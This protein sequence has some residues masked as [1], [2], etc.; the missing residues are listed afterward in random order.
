MAQHGHPGR[1]VLI[2][3]V[4]EA[5]VQ[6]IQIVYLL[7]RR[8]S[9][10]QDGVLHLFAIA[11]DGGDSGAAGCIV[12]RILQRRRH[13]DYMGQGTHRHRVVVGKLLAGQHLSGRASGKCGKPIQ[14]QHIGA[15][16]LHQPRHALVQPIHHRRDGDHGHHADYD[17]QDRQPAAHLVGAQ[18]VQRH[19]HGL[20]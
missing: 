19:R 20:F 10:G 1:P 6:H 15:E 12:V 8:R 11:A 5:S 14:E 16:R 3:V 7:L 2:R 4:E 13:R 17:A 18:R 9:T